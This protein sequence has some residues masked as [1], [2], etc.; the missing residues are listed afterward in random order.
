MDLSAGVHY[1]LDFYREEVPMENMFRVAII[2]TP[3]MTPGQAANAAAIVSGGMVCDAFGAP[4]ADL[5]GTLHAAIRWNLVVLEARSASFLATVLQTA[6][7]FG[8]HAVAFS[9]L[10][11]QL[12][13]SF[14]AYRDSIAEKA[15]ADLELIAVG[16]Y[17][18]D[19]D[20]RKLTKPCSLF[21]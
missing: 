4:I 14:E 3:K 7:E 16:L 13:N 6:K 15:S 20:V 21:R 5:N 1:V 19:E 11:Q 10:G 8:I 17:G 9:T 2:L 12:S 18:R